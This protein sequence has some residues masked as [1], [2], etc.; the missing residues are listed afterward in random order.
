MKARAIVLLDLDYFYCQV[1]MLRNGLPAERPVAVTQ[2]FLVVTC[3]YPARSSGVAKLMRTTEAVA[4]C[5]DLRL[6]AG[7]D[8]TPYREASDEA[9]QALRAFGP[10]QRVGLDEFFIDV[11]AVAEARAS[12]GAWAPGTHARAAV[13]RATGLTSS[14]GVAHNKLLA[15]LAA[16]LHKP[17]AQTALPASEASA[18]VAPLPL[19]ALPGVGAR[20][21]NC[22]PLRRVGARAAAALH[23]TGCTTVAEA[24]E[25]GL[26]ALQRALGAAAGRRLAA[27]CEG[28]C[29]EPVKESG[30]PLSVTVEDSFKAAHSV[31]ALRL[32][33]QVLAPDLRRRL[34]D[35][36]ASRGAS[37]VEGVRWRHHGTRT[38]QNPTGERDA[39][40]A[41][42]GPLCVSRS[43]AM[44]SGA[45][46]ER[47]AAAIAAAAEAVLRANLRPPQ[48][49]RPPFHLT[50]LALSATK[51]ARAGGL[52]AGGLRDAAGSR[53]AIAG[54]KGASPQAKQAAAAHRDFRSGYQLG[55]GSPVVLMSKA[56]ER[57]DWSEWAWEGGGEEE[58]CGGDEEAGGAEPHDVGP[59]FPSPRE[60][61]ARSPSG[62]A[63]ANEA[64]EAG[65]AE[66]AEAA[67]AADWGLAG[68]NH[69]PTRS[70]VA[71]AARGGRESAIE[72]TATTREC[73]R[74]GS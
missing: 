25:A 19:R 52:Q 21:A 31:E 62:E 45:S 64:Q 73:R 24:R 9:M 67:E 54:E 44:P 74:H 5:P 48:P 34:A 30:P 51:F 69:L 70:E 1:E 17:D 66:A 12:A 8:L 22:V 10:V 55:Q 28:A 49:S 37:A 6:I 32:V 3:N 71:P 46:G 20:S 36:A 58:L 23:A 43:C 27:Q 47:G 60:L 33:L 68:R 59:C 26:A 4:R 18:F 56:E 14:A 57:R 42:R 61:G 2:K 50:L 40:V 41:P 63:G 53:G 35:E 38:M 7:E 72:D 39:S 11:T 16:S 13:R 15:K 65:S 29:A